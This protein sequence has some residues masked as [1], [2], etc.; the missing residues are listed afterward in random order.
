[1]IIEGMASDRRNLFWTL[2]HVLLGFLCTVTPVFLIVWFYFIFLTNIR[3]SITFLTNKKP[4]LFLLLFS[5]LIS[6]EVLDRMAKTSPFIPYE[7]GKYFLVIVGILG[8]FSFGIRNNMGL[9]YLFLISPALLY[10]FS[11]E[12]NYFDIINYYLGPLAVGLI[13]AFA[14]GLMV[15]KSAFNQILK[16]L[17]WGCL[18]S[19]VYTFIKTP[20]IE[21]IEFSLKAQFDTT[22]GHSSN[23]VSTLLGF[24]MFLS[25]Y[26][27]L[28]QLKFS[29]NRI[30]DLFILIGFTFQGLLS[31]SRGGMIVGL[32]GIILLVI[33][34]NAGQLKINAEKKLKRSFLIG[35][36]AFVSLY[37]VFEVANNI[38][39]GNLLLRYQGETQGTLLGNKEKTANHITTGRL[40]IFEKDFIL[41]FEYP[42]TGVGC[43]ISQYLRDKENGKVASHLEFSR[44]FAD[45]GVLGAIG[46]YLLFIAVPFRVWKKNKYSTN[47]YILFVLLI[48]AL[49][50]T[51]HAAIR[52]F[53]TPLLI[54]LAILKIEDD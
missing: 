13:L 45:H 36:V 30:F 39:R 24:G 48:V 22:G 40:E 21:E 4:I 37:G 44:M 8:V 7:L 26:S 54:L 9:L 50:T 10:D 18:A 43:G 35:V 51:F 27:V 1:M 15:S 3:K 47:R 31:F 6:F 2:F 25:F 11:G 49:V 5:Y 41:F 23:Q 38:T 53:V 12:R 34:K 42:L 20:D 33:L 16:F 17:F 32:L 19:L 29:G 28:N 14:D 46:A 52:T